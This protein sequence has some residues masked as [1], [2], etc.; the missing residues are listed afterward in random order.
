MTKLK[1]RGLLQ[2]FLRNS[3]SRRT[4]CAQVA[5]IDGPGRLLVT[6][7]ESF[8]SF[9]R[10]KQKTESFECKDC[11]AAKGPALPTNVGLLEI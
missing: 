10:A 6:N 8:W 1:E 9:C 3:N 11:K 5:T 2:K 4:F 7:E